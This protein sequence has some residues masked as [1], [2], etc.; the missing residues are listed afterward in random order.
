MHTDHSLIQLLRKISFCLVIISV[1]S[2]DKLMADDH[3]THESQRITPTVLA[4]AKVLPSVV[5]ISTERVVTQR[6]PRYRRNDPFAEV[7]NRFFG[8]QEKTY[9]TN[10]LGSGVVV[11]SRGLIVTNNHVIQKASK[12]IVNLADGANYEAKPIA[13][14]EANDLALIML[15]D[16]DRKLNLQ[17]IDFAAPD[18]LLLGERV[19][20][21]GNPYGLGHS[22]TEG[23]LSA[24]GRKVVYEGDVLFDD[25]LQTDAAINPGNSGGPLI[26]ADGQLI[27][28]NLAIH[29]D[30][31]GIGFAIPLKRIEEVLSVWL[32]PSCFGM[33]SCGFFPETVKTPEGQILVS[34]KQITPDSAAQKSGLKEGEIIKSVNDIPVT[35]AIEVGRLLWQMKAGDPVKLQLS[36]N[37]II[38]FAIEAVPKL[39]G[40]ELAKIKLKVE[41]QLLNS[42]LAE[43]LGL[44]YSRGLVVSKVGEGSVL[45]RRGVQRG[46]V[47]KQIGEVP[48]ADFDDLGRALIDTTNQDIVQY[49]VDRI[50]SNSGHIFLHRYI[51]DVSL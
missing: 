41:L 4:V 25:I 24:K 16:F 36:D 40:E 14:D 17:A 49:V 29:D 28:I 30:A 22:V 26:N 2:P 38:S 13:T 44:P 45:A 50:Q 37:R 18:D 12:I 46:D 39:S 15:V 35:H 51:L 9:K 43:A 8:Y 27:G 20:S 34:I 10:S 42:N 7:F 11:D 47:I 19:I 48:I 21:V 32:V 5:N 23:V 1:I 3:T 33:N 6:F 31:E